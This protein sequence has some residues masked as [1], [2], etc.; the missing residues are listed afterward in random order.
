MSMSYSKRAHRMEY[1]LDIF[2]KTISHSNIMVKQQIGIWLHQQYQLHTG[3]RHTVREYLSTQTHMLQA[4]E[5]DNLPLIWR[6][7]SL[8]EPCLLLTSLSSEILAKTFRGI[9]M[10]EHQADKIQK[11]EHQ[12]NH[13]N[14]PAFLP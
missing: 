4:P 5:L 2:A 7:W 1:L 10:T 3:E 8:P 12:L 9:Y 11:N 6:R 14:K 13:L